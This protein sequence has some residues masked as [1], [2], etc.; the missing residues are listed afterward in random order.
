MSN[1]HSHTI[2]QHEQ[3]NPILRKLVEPLTHKDPQKHQ[4]IDKSR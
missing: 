4:E 3:N 2:H 1:R